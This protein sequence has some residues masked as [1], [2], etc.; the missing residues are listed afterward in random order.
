MNAP[1]WCSH[2][3]PPHTVDTLPNLLPDLHELR[4]EFGF[5]TAMADG[6]GTVVKVLCYKSEGR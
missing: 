5:F 6:G 4:I 3:S 2:L 1:L